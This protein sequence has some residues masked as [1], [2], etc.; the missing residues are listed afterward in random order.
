MCHWLRDITLSSNGYF[1]SFLITVSYNQVFSILN[2]KFH[3]I[4]LLDKSK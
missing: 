2:L 3:L 1:H 4:H